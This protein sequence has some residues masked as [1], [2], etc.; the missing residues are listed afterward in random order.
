[1]QTLELPFDDPRW[2]A[3][4]NRDNAAREQFVYAVRTTGVF[5]RPGCAS[6]Q[7]RRENVLFFDT[8]AQARAA[9]FRPCQ[10]CQPEH[11][12]P[13]DTHSA[14]I[15]QACRLLEA[16][17][18]LPNLTAL[19][20]AAGLSAAHFHR[21]FKAAV[22]VTPRAYGAAQ[23]ARRVQQAL[24]S[25]P[26]V[27]AAL[28]AA[29]YNA[30]SRF[31]ADAPA[32]LGMAP[33]EYQAGAAGQELRWAV[34]PCYLGL[35]LVA[36]TASGVCSIE[37]GDDAT[38]LEARLRARFPR[39]QFAAGDSAFAAWLAQVVACIEAPQRSLTLP[40]N[41]QGTAFQ[42]RVWEALGAIP[43]GQTR[44]YAEVADSIGQPTATRAVAQAC[45][46]SQLAVA[47]PCH[48][49]VRS[50]GSL[51]GYRWGPERKRQLLERESER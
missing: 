40:L 15:Q 46:A 17:D 28:Y 18:E 41:I 45:A 27:T 16:A 35:V 48:R 11:D 49:V 29:G 8:P 6:R 26:S 19:A 23:R 3:V 22:G 2:A 36:A 32:A 31:Y 43:A 13:A 5:C 30:S 7:P 4:C 33:R 24:Q 9:G 12:L 34:A 51:S 37:L 21:V 39:A 10:R 25:A 47:I 50:D 20:Q 42:R 38:E 44:S 14:A 1:M